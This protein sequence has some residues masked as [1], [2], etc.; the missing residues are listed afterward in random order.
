LLK[1]EN[2]S[3]LADY[4]RVGMNMSNFSRQRLYQCHL[5]L[6]FP[7]G[8]GKKQSMIIAGLGNPG[9]E[10]ENTRHNA[11]FWAADA[12]AAR[13]RVDLNLRQ[14]QAITGPLLLHG[15][16]HLLVKPQT[17]MNLSG[18]ALAGLMIA[19]DTAPEELL[20]ILDDINLPAGRIRMRACGS[21]GGHNGLK[22]IIS[23]IGRNFWRLRIGVGQPAEDENNPHHKLVSHVLGTVTT[24]EMAVFRL[25]LAEIPEMAALWLLGMGNKAMTRYNGIDFLNPETRTD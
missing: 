6:T 15:Q 17:Y 2:T 7:H 21:D 19:N 3:G 10:Y 4:N 22:S 14:H 13:F 18:E 8:S 25:V 12:I 9:K 5:R 1:I 24:E 16:Q 23:H 11:G 20:V